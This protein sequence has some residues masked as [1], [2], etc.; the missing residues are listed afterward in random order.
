MAFQEE[1][2]MPQI[3]QNPSGAG[4]VPTDTSGVQRS[5]PTFVPGAQNG[6]S[7]PAAVISPD[8]SDLRGSV[9]FG[10]G[11]VPSIG[12][13]LVCTFTT[14]RDPSRLPVVQ[15]TETTTAFSALQPAVV[16]TATGF[17]V[18]TAVAPAA[19]QGNTIYGFGWTL[20]D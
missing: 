9:T 10:S 2:D 20:T 16:V 14:P 17:T 18:S 1:P 15:L 19:S 3:V 12:A 7:P 13:Q 5:A 11:T 6:G 8:S 4:G